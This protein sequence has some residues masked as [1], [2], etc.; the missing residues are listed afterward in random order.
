MHALILLV[1]LLAAVVQETATMAAAHDLT[2][3]VRDGQGRPLPEV[4]LQ[5]LHNRG[6]EVAP[7]DDGRQGHAQTDAQGRHTFRVP[8]G[9]YLL[10]VHG[11]VAGRPLQPIAQ[12]GIGGADEACASQPGF[13]IY[14]AEL[15]Q[16]TV[17]IVI[18]GLTSDG[19]ALPLWDD[20]AT[21]TDPVKAVSA[22]TGQP[23]DPEQA[24]AQLAVTTVGAA[25][26]AAPL[27]AATAV[28]GQVDAPALTIT[29]EAQGNTARNA[30]LLLILV[31]LPLA[32]IWWRRREAA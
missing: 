18:G 17:R 10:Q 26:A 8:W 25:P 21:D 13:C 3:L 12:Q 24:A 23:A 9:S 6:G 31:L 32:G 27:P 5:L 7:A 15:E 2:I 20:A 16:L 28:A 11:S 22:Q 14:F 29:P 19:L 30:W 1:V 4:H